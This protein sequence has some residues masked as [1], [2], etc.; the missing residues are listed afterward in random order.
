VR[1]LVLLSDGKP[2]DDAYVDEYALEDT[3]MALQEVRRQGLH[4]FCITVDR[5]AD[6]YVRRM[7]GDVRYLVIDQAAAL[8]E[9]LPRIYQRLT[10]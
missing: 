7:Y 6:E 9:K 3:K 8:P 1:L 5:D 10:A 4:P 2:L